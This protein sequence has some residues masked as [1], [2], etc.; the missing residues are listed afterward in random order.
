M[1]IIG[2]IIV[3]LVA[4]AIRGLTYRYG[5]VC[6]RLISGYNELINGYQL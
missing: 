6:G 4:N 2:N 3:L 1:F 5:A